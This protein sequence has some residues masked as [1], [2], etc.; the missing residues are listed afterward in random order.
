ML[1][2]LLGYDIEPGLTVEEYERWLWQVHVPD[3]LANPHLGRL[4]FNRVIRPVTQTSAGTPT[5]ERAESF[6]RIAEM[7]FEDMGAY[8]RYLAWFREHPIP[9]QR[10]PAGRTA[11]R[12][13]VLAESVEATRDAPPSTRQTT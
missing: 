4:V 7:H 13:Y 9:P 1:K 5:G 12:F 6:Y 2:T 8:E 3:L 11:F 10:G